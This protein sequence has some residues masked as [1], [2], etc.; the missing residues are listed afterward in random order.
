MEMT[1]ETSQPKL[2]YFL[3][4]D[5]NLANAIWN[6]TVINAPRDTGNLQRNISMTASTRKKIEIFY[7]AFNAPYLH[8]LEEGIGPIKKHQGYI[9]EK[10]V[11]D[12]FN[13]LITYYKKGL[14]G[15]YARPTITLKES[16]HGPMFSEK[17]LLKEMK[18][19]LNSVLN[20]D[21]RMQLGRIYARSSLGDNRKT[22]RRG[23]QVEISSRGYKRSS[24]RTFDLFYTN[25]TLY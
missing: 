10:T 5:T 14:S 20:A 1:I 17:K 25:E 21:E 4:F 18:Q 16:K 13:L 22:S 9:N 11:G 23:M 7:N 19:N 3:G 24:T 8:F 6:I 2:N 15:I 12:V